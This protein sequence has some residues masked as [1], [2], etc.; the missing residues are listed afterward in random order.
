MAE[1][2]AGS[3][4]AQMYTD[5]DKTWEQFL[6]ACMKMPDNCALAKHA[7][8]SAELGKKLDRLIEELKYHPIPAGKDIIDYS[9]VKFS[10][11]SLSIVRANIQTWQR[12]SNP[13]SLETRQLWL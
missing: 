11:S 9:A 3:G 10:P 1:S 4:D 12:N 13:C 7:T 6:N 5:T 8:T 2:K